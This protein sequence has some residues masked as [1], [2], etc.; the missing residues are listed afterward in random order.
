MYDPK[1]QGHPKGDTGFYP[2]FAAPPFVPFSFP[3]PDAVMLYKTEPRQSSDKQ[4][5][6]YC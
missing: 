1:K 4:S 5:C 2:A 3:V 6:Y